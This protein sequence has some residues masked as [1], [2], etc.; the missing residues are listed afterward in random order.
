MGAVEDQKAVLATLADR[1]RDESLAIIANL[2]NAL[3]LLKVVELAEQSQRL[4]AASTYLRKF[5]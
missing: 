1:C 3:P 4:A 2:D 5:T